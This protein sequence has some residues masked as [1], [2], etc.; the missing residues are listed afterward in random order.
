MLLL[1]TSLLTV[2]AIWVAVYVWLD[3]RDER[4]LKNFLAHKHPPTVWYSTTSAAPLDEVTSP[5]PFDE[6]QQESKR[7]NGH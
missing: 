6:L 2:V 1:L 4:S 3:S 7:A 5:A